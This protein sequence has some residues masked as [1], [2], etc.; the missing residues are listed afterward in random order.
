MKNDQ[1]KTMSLYPGVLLEQARFRP[2]LHRRPVIQQP[3]PDHDLK[4][5]CCLLWCV[6]L[7]RNQGRV[8]VTGVDRVGV[9]RVGVDRVGFDPRHCK[10]AS[11]ES[12][13]AGLRV[14]R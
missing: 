2:A 9:D 3:R 11:D 7:R 1:I 12:C 6:G 10:R 8:R 14:T 5:E 13:M 4:R